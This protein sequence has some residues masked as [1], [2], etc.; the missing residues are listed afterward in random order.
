MK[1]KL[2][3]GVLSA[4]AVLLMVTGADSMAAASGDAKLDS[5]VKKAN[6]DWAAAMK[7]GDAA[8]IAAPY[9]DDA[10]FVGID[11][12]CLRGRDAIKKLY[13]TR[14]D[15]TGHASSTTINAKSIILDGDLAYESGDAEMGFVKDGKP[16]VRGGRYLTVWQRQADGDWKILRNIVLP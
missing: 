1:T 12:T 6:D 7:T 16:V 2:R 10:V 14:F 13:D 15:Q 11:G 9:A 3:S 5:A 4:A 8:A